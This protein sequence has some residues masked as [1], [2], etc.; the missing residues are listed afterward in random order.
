MTVS[1]MFESKHLGIFIFRKYAKTTKMWWTGERQGEKTNGRTDN[2]ILTVPL[3]P[4][5]GNNNSR[6]YVCME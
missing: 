6:E 3:T 1:T 4:L 2:T 5:C